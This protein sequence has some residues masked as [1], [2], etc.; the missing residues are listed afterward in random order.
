MPP[1]PAPAGVSL[2]DRI[3]RPLTLDRADEQAHPRL[4][5]GR[6]VLD[7]C[8]DGRLLR[9]RSGSPTWHRAMRHL[10]A[11]DATCQHPPGWQRPILLRSLATIAHRSRQ[12]I[13]PVPQE[14]R[15]A[16]RRGTAAD[17]LPGSSRTPRLLPSCAPAS[18]GADVVLIAKA[19][20]PNSACFRPSSNGSALVSLIVHDPSAD[21]SSSTKGAKIRRPWR[22]RHSDASGGALLAWPATP[23][24]CAPP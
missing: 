8:A 17:V 23:R 22:A 12:G 18:V 21:G 2:G 14:R 13:D 4:L 15:S 16:D 20:T 9:V 10:V 24:T 11:I 7:W 5:P 6:H 3:E 19:G 1:P